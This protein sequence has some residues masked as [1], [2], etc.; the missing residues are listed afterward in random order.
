MRYNN[1]DLEQRSK[2]L[3]KQHMDYT[4]IR[5]LVHW[6]LMGGLLYSEDGRG[7]AAAPPSPF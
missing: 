6:P 3:V 4:A 1:V 5:R 2:L 7:Q